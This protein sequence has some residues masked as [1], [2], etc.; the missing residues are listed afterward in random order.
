VNYDVVAGAG[1]C[2]RPCTSTGVLLQLVSRGACSC[3]PVKM[4]ET[5]V[6][7]CARL[8]SPAPDDAQ[9]HLLITHGAGAGPNG[10]TGIEESGS[11]G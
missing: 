3:P 4:S 11:D 7:T 5:S 10:I 9:R 8:E 2:W 6:K 1:R